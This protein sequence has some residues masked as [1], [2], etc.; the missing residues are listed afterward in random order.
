MSQLA[1]R[2]NLCKYVTWWLSVISKSYGLLARLLTRCFCVRRGAPV[3]VDERASSVSLLKQ[4][5]SVKS[6]LQSNPCWGIMYSEERCEQQHA[7]NS[8]WTMLKTCVYIRMECYSVRCCN[9]VFPLFPSRQDPLVVCVGAPW[10]RPSRWRSQT[11]A[12]MF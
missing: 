5:S 11:L 10:P 12:T 7:S 1:T 3:V 4:I 6:T 9:C 8:S 2:D